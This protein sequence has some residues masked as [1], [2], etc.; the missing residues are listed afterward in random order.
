METKKKKKVTEEIKRKVGF[1]NMSVVS[2]VGEGRERELRVLVMFCRENMDLT[3]ISWSINHICVHTKDKEL[4]NWD[5]CGLYG[6]PKEMNK[7]KTFELI[8]E[9]CDSVSTTLVLF[10]DLGVS[11]DPGGC[12]Y[13]KPAT[14]TQRCK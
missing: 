14:C 11:T 2:C 7:I 6:W 4:G 3:L 5:L 10:G 8:K 9:V 13:S 12:E 1:K